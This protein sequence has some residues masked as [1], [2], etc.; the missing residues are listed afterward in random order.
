MIAPLVPKKQTAILALSAVLSGFS[1]ASVL[2]FTDPYTAAWAVFAFFYLSLFLFCF[3][4]L[5]LL[6]YGLKRWLW[7]KIYLSDLGASLRQGL[8]LAAFISLS[9]ALQ[10]NGILFWWLEASLIL[11]FISLE[12]FISLKT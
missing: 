12:V 4:I 5:T 7:P 10:M 3:C 1:L 6:A 9:V 8:L 2:N 11:F